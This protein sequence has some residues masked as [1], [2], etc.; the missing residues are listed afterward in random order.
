MYTWVIL[1]VLG[2]ATCALFACKA[3]GNKPKGAPP[4][5]SAKLKTLTPEEVK[6]LLANVKKAEAPKPKMGAMCYDMA[7][8]PYR[9]EYVC[10]T[11]GEKTLYPPGT[12]VFQEGELD[13]CRRN[14]ELLK[15]VAPLEVTL[16]ESSLCRKCRP[17]AEHQ[18]LVLT[19]RFK[20]GAAH[21]TSPVYAFDL[22]LLCDFFNETLSTATSNGGEE[23]L[24]DH[25]LRIHELLGIKDE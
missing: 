11:C 9:A 12:A 6:V 5:T 4:M 2:F 10:P 19:V 21:T 8:S 14:F 17:K 3:K 15:K 25:L 7:V 16:D 1:L 18:A 23:P 24:K 22:Q 20:D 13:H